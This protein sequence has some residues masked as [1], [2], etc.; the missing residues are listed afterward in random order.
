MK[1]PKPGYANPLV[2]LHVFRLHSYYSVLQEAGEGNVDK[3]HLAQQTTVQLE[4]TGHTTPED[5]I[6]SEVAWVG[7][8]T[9]LVREVT[10][11]ADDG[12]VILFDMTTHSWFQ[13]TSVRRLGKDGEQGDD[14]WID[15]VRHFVS[16]RHHS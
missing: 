12:A 6:V 2:S 10:R 13:G 8:D 4:W 16:A 14:G 1:Y 11:S 9:L 5:R 7:D 15:A 3:S